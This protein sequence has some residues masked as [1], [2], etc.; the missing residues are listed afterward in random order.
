MIALLIYGSAQSI[1]K[2]WTNGSCNSRYTYQRRDDVETSKG[3]WFI[4]PSTLL[5]TR[6]TG[7]RPLPSRQP[8]CLVK[9]RKITEL[10]REII[11]EYRAASNICSVRFVVGRRTPTRKVKERKGS[12]IPHLRERVAIPFRNP[13][14]PTVYVYV[15]DTCYG[16]RLSTLPMHWG[17]DS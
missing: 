7:K 3:K 14:C 2:A 9:R 16:A 10:I 4:W 17:S 11:A 13:L 1:I 5:R 6:Q 8:R 12:G 15:R